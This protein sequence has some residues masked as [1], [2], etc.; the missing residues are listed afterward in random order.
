MP[1]PP[2]ARQPQQPESFEPQTA[3]SSTAR[4][5]PTLSGRS[6]IKAAQEILRSQEE[7]QALLH[8]KHQIER[9]L[10]E[11]DEVLAFKAR[12]EEKKKRP[13]AERPFASF[14]DTYRAKP[15]LSMVTP[16]IT[17]SWER[18]RNE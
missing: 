18:E 12:Q 13:A 11:L 4:F 1:V 2:Y 6:P 10:K 14:L 3:P 7:H 15:E 8:Q 16:T 17:G 9:Q 5:E